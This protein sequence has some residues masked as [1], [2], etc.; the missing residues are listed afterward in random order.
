MPVPDTSTNAAMAAA[1]MAGI[2]RVAAL[3]IVIDGNVFR[4]YES[5]HLEQSASSH[6]TFRLVLQHDILPAAQGHTLE[7]ARHFL[8]R[9]ISVTFK[10]KGLG[11]SGPEREFI[12][13][14]T[15]VAFSGQHAC[16]K[17]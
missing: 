13:V 6:H 1:D 11:R 4:H 2:I 16:R 3:E 5:F 7:D 9:R 10:Y 17:P 15:G 8:G 12:G 14:I